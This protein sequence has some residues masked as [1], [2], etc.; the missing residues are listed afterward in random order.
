M[1]KLKLDITR[2]NILLSFVTA[3]A[4]ST[5]FILITNN[6]TP[7]AFTF[8]L[9]LA[10]PYSR[11]FFS[12]RNKQILDLTNADN[13]VITFEKSGPISTMEYKKYWLFAILVYGLIF[14]SYKVFLQ[15]SWPR[16]I[17]ILIGVIL[18]TSY[19][20]IKKIPTRKSD[21]NCCSR[22]YFNA[23]DPIPYKSP[24]IRQDNTYNNPLSDYKPIEYPPIPDP[25]G[26]GSTASN[27]L[28]PYK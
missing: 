4:I 20:F 2:Q 19:L 14:V 9:S 8:C 1:E 17:A 10:S 18:T 11:L 16:A 13:S 24:E 25:T 5:V 15:D 12:R 23:I 26:L 7:V 6:I 28:N 21:F 3:I 22:T 27:F